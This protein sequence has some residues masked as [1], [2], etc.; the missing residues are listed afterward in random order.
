MP[1]NV[2]SSADGDVQRP[3]LPLRANNAFFYYSELDRATEFYAGTLGY[4]IVADYGKART[5][6][7]ASSSFLTLVD[8][9]IGMHK[10]DEPKTVTL[11]AVVN[12][13]Q[14]WYSYLQSKGV[15]IHKELTFQEGRAY[16]G[17]VAL[18]PEGYLLEFVHFNPHP[19][20]ADLLPFLDKLPQLQNAIDTD[21]PNVNLHVSA[22]ILWLYYQDMEAAHHFMQETLGLKKVYDRGIATIYAASQSGFLGTVMAGKGLHPY[23]EQKAITISLLTD[24][25]EK[26]HSWIATQPNV[27]FRTGEIVTRER[28][29]A[30]VAYIPENYYLEFNTFLEHPDNQEFV[31]VLRLLNTQ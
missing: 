12:D 3:T 15:P 7:I 6:Q 21:N 1:T 11:A 20:N 10:P 28:Y 17:F 27:R 16:D 23:S 22:T 18:D 24:E 19:D 5:L 26:W 4:K 25:I 14:S 30:L 29:K 9:T 8:G 2:D 31:R 13:V